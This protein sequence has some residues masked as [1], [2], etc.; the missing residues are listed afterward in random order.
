M[1]MRLHYTKVGS[2]RYAVQDSYR[3][4]Y[5]LFSLFMVYGFIAI[6]GEEGALTGALVFPVLLLLLSLIGFGYRESWSFNP[7]TQSVHYITGWLFLVHHQEYSFAAIERLEIS[8]FIRGHFNL[9]QQGRLYNP[10]GRNKAMVVFSLVLAS[11]LAKDI[12]IITERTSG[13]R[14]EEAAQAIATHCGLA[15][16][17]DRDVDVVQQVTVRDL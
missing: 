12:E 2:V 15:F 11:G 13:G 9:G 7:A 3:V 17:K 5:A 16:A 10:K 4:L 1:R 8:H 6:I 14:T